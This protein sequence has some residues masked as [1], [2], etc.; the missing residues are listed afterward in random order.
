MATKRKVRKKRINEDQLVTYY[1]K[2][3]RLAQ[4][5]FN[6]V[7]TGIIVLV[8][9]IAASIFI[10]QSR[11]SSASNSERYLGAALALMR[12][13]D[14]AAAKTSFQD[15]HDRYA[16]TR[17]GVVALYFKA[18]CDLALQNFGEALDGFEAYLHKANKFPD[19]KAT[20]TIGKTLALEGLNR[21]GDAADVLDKL[22]PDLNPK[23]PRYAASLYRV[24]VLSDKI[25]NSEKAVQYLQKVIDIGSGPYL[26]EAEVKMAALKSKQRG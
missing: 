10:I 6:Q 1:L 12:Q 7:L 20:A 24:A 13:G 2:V 17:A 15:A 19:F 9:I 8:V 18:E 25:G 23:D 16:N 11:K 14:V 5:H 4:K 21:P 22:I 26:E 3:T